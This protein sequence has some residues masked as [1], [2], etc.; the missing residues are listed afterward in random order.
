MVM[1][2]YLAV[3]SMLGTKK[4]DCKLKKYLFYKYGSY[5]N[6]RGNYMIHSMCVCHPKSSCCLHLEA[7]V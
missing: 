4:A 7:I 3:K 1:N 6:H 2:A 5:N